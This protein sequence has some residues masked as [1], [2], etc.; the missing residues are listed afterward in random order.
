MVTGLVNRATN[1][2]THLLKKKLPNVKVKIDAMSNRQ[3]TAWAGG[4]IL[5]SLPNLKGFWLTKEE[6]ADLGSDRVK[7]KFF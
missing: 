1:E 5:A 2:L 6:Y 3:N 4:S 7:S